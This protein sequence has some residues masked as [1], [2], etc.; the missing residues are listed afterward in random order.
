MITRAA[1][2]ADT[3]KGISAKCNVGFGAR[4]SEDT[5]ARVMTVKQACWMPHI[6]TS[7][8]ELAQTS[9]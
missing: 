6:M 5:F 2:V 4:C 3:T 8:N 7:S 1:M 9:L